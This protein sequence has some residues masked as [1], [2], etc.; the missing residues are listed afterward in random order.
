MGLL[1]NIKNRPAS[2]K[3]SSYDERD[4]SYDTGEEPSE[5]VWEGEERAERPDEVDAKR[6]FKSEK[7]WSPGDGILRIGK[8]TPHAWTPLHRALVESDA[9]RSLTRPQLQVLL[10]LMATRTA[11]NN[12]KLTVTLR[13][14]QRSFN[15]KKSPDTLMRSL[16]N[17]RKLQ[18]VERVQ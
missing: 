3:R 12:G 6:E 17:L 10:Y 16:K 4:G 9:F 1:L 2:V 8:F 13:D 15:W 14:M 18:F 11:F 5:I 7:R